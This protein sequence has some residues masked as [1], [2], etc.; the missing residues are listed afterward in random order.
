VTFD[1]FGDFST[2]GYLRNSES[3][4]DL[5]EVKRLEHRG[6]LKNLPDAVA[7]LKRVARVSY[8][9]VLDTHKVLFQDVYP[10]AGQDRQATAPNIAIARGGRA[11]MFAHPRFIQDA[12]HYALQ[13]AEATMTARPGEVMGYLAHAHPF[14]DGNGRTLMVVHNELAHRAGIS[15]DWTKTNKDD[16]LQALTRELDRPGA[17]GL[18]TYLKPFVGPSASRARATAVLPKMRGFA[19]GSDTK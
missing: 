14:L 9:D 17:G 3:L 11:D 6:F 18:D 10:W 12:V 8:Q 1:A 16:Y 7:H 5:A 19:G 13:L 2:R 15:I 4:K